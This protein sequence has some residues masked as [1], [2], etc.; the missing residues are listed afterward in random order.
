MST[1]LATVTLARLYMQQGHLDRAR[2]MIQQILARAPESGPAR[3]LARRLA[4]RQA[5]ELELELAEDDTAI[6]R[7]RG[8]P[9]DPSAL[10]DRLGRTDARLYIVLLAFGRGPGR[11]AYV[12]SRRCA[13]PRGELIVPCGPRPGSVVACLSAA[14]PGHP[15]RPLTVAT[16]M[17]WPGP[18]DRE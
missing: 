17:T 14:V 13:R 12:T 10:L 15:P 9:C 1:G 5:I 3:V 16:P 7:W 2:G 18:P 11:P 8:A 4:I 6:I